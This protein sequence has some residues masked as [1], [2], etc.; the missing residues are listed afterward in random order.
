MIH[1]KFQDNLTS[2]SETENLLKVLPCMGM[3]A[4]LPSI[5]DHSYKLTFPLPKGHYLY[6][7]YR[8]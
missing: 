2:G 5:L 1:T 3:V 7:S 4:I 8:D 6:K